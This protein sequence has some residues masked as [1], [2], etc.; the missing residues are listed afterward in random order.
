MPVR[1]AVPQPGQSLVDV[2]VARGEALHHDYS[3]QLYTGVFGALAVSTMVVGA[4][5]SRFIT[6]EGR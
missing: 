6:A 2:E 3:L 5:S 4:A 1:Q